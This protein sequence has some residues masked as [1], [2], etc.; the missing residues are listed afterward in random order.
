MKSLVCSPPSSVPGVVMVLLL[1][2]CGGHSP[3]APLTQPPPPPP[4]PQPQPVGGNVTG[5]VW[6]FVHDSLGVCIPAAVVEILDGPRAG[7]SVTQDDPCGGIWD[8]SG[9][10]SFSGLPANVNVR[11]R[12]SKKGY[13]SLEMTFSTT[14]PAGESNFLL[15]PE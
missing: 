7:D 3:T 9:G 4:Q 11:M 10:Y 2:S 12:A 5:L 15:V 1:L 8:Y 6:G 14:V 13:V